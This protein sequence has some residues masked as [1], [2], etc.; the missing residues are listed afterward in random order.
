MHQARAVLARGD[1]VVVF[2][3]GTRVRPG[4]LGTPKRR[5]GRPALEPRVPLVP[6]AVLGTQDMRRG[7]RLRPRRVYGRAPLPRHFPPRGTAA[8]ALAAPLTDP[9]RP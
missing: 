2:P 4:P 5:V 8:P 9:R 7:W 6:I 1:C 3:E